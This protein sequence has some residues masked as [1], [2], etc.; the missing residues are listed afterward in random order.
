MVTGVQRPATLGLVFGSR[1]ANFR[2]RVSYSSGLVGGP[3]ELESSIALANAPLFLR[4]SGDRDSWRITGAIDGVA[5]ADPYP[6]YFYSGPVYVG[7]VAAGEPRVE[8]AE[9]AD[10]VALEDALDFVAEG[11]PSSLA[12]DVSRHLGVGPTEEL[13]WSAPAAELFREPLSISLR[14]DDAALAALVDRLVDEVRSGPREKREVPLR[15][16]LGLR[17]PLAVE[18]WRGLAAHPDPLVAERVRSILDY[19]A[20]VPRRR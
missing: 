18:R 7:A 8:T 5:L 1:T 16:L 19:R 17:A 12:L 4:L 15:R 3:I 10:Y 14:R 9:L 11:R 20:K 2:V 13:A 6:G